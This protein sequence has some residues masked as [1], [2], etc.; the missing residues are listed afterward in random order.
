MD[1]CTSDCLDLSWRPAPVADLVYV[2][3]AD[4][5]EPEPDAFALI[6]VI[7]YGERIA[8]EARERLAALRTR[9]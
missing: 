6:G 3:D 1:F 5:S 8:A 4:V 2:R 9:G 7:E